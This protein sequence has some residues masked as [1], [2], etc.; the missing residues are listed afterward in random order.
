MGFL[1]KILHQDKNGNLIDVL[2]VCQT[3]KLAIKKNAIEHAIDLIARIISKCEIEHYKYN[4]NKH[5]LD[6]IKSSDI[7]YRLNI[8]PN[9]NEIAP[10]FIYNAVSRLLKDK[11]ILII[12]MNHKL[13]LASSFNYDSK[14]LNEKTFS[15]I[16]LEDNDGNTLLL[17][18][19]F[20]SSECL[21]LS[22]GISKIKDC[23]DEYYKDI[24]KLISIQNQKYIMSNINKWKLNVPGTQPKMIDPKTGETI[25]YKEYKEKLTDGLMDQEDAIIMLSQDFNLQKLAGEEKYTSDDLLNLQ[26]KWEKDVAKAFNI[27][28]DVY[29]GSKID[30]S[31]GTDDLIT[32]AVTPITTILEAGFNSSLIKKE[33]FLNGN[34]IKF[35][36]L[37]I[38]HFDIFDCANSIDKLISSGFSH[39]E[40][41]YFLGIP[42]TGE[43]WAQKHHI[44]KNYADVSDNSGGDSMT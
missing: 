27:P 25:D 40:N 26:D 37:N 18:R 12:E 9:D 36:T 34:M 35:N 19:T 39:D 4:S 20:K 8:K 21:Y 6:R 2:T 28:L 29:Y 38:K 10:T 1:T 30:K 5:K 15:N 31:T 17:E 22:L 41:R 43:E 42:E 32:F 16:V 23:L 33:D 13:Y 11:E 24:G 7:Y 14:I 44:T 3:Q